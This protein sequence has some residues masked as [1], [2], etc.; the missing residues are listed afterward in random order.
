M[1]LYCGIPPEK[2]YEACITYHLVQY[3]KTLYSREI[4]PFS[5]TQFREK[6][7]GF[8]FGY[9]LSSENVFLGQYK[10]P[11]M[12]EDG[13]Y[14]WRIDSEQ[15]N[16]LSK[17][18]VPAFYILPAFAE[19]KEWYEGLDKT[20][21]VPVYLVCSWAQRREGKR[22]MVIRDTD[23]LLRAVREKPFDR[24]GRDF[25]QAALAENVQ[26]GTSLMEY[27]ALLQ[28][29]ASDDIWGYWIKG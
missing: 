7:L 25:N 14:A 18:P 27:A 16:T 29:N 11:L 4:Y 6:S 20:Y 26:T 19:A 9:E 2:Y 17:S 10:R 15:M 24:F 8:D 28:E 22:L 3:F 5:I 23:Q 21:F 1:E 12:L 13:H